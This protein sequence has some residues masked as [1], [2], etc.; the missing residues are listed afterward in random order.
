MK[1]GDF[2]IIVLDV[3]KASSCIGDEGD[4]DFTDI[5]NEQM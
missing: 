1:D 5:S 4:I 2:T 3:V